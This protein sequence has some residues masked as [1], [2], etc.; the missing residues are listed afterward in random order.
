MAIT[1]LIAFEEFYK[2]SQIEN[3]NIQQNTNHLDPLEN[4]QM[5]EIPKG[6]TIP[7]ITIMN[8]AGITNILDYVR[9]TYDIFRKTVS[10]D[11]V[12]TI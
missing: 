12:I 5:L 2:L 11:G 1:L 4:N 8:N 7:A 9:P 3:F 6:A 10:D